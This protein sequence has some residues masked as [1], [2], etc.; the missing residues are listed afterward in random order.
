MNEDA[1]SCRSATK[2]RW[3]EQNKHSFETAGNSA[4]NLL[5]LKLPNKSSK[6]LFEDPETNLVDLN[7]VV[8]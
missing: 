1:I 2:K 3:N 7:D 5:F 6:M 8:L 4:L